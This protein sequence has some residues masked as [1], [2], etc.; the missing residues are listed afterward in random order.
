MTKP[1]RF[2]RYFRPEMKLKL[3]SYCENLNC[4]LKTVKVNSLDFQNHLRIMRDKIIIKER[5][6]SVS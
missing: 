1:T 3:E 5:Y 6:T 2:I 4:Y